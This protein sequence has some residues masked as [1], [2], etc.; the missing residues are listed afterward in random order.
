MSPCPWH[1]VCREITHSSATHIA[2]QGSQ[3]TA[4]QM[5]SD[6]CLGFIWEDLLEIWCNAESLKY[7]FHYSDTW[8]LLNLYFPPPSCLRE[9]HFSLYPLHFYCLVD[10]WRLDLWPSAA[11]VT[12]MVTLWKN[13]SATLL[14]HDCFPLHPYKALM[15]ALLTHICF[16]VRSSSI[17]LE[18]NAWSVF[19]IFFCSHDLQELP[20][21]PC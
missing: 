12:T 5:E 4:R 11:S 15:A 20:C 3:I 19:S 8:Q 18:L 2:N 21:S 10:P 9:L 7:S 13:P 6:G 16:L 1:W 14:F 17:D